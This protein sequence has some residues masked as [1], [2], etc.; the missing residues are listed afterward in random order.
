[1]PD[2]EPGQVRPFADVLHEIERGRFAADISE[3]LHELTT[4]VADTK[5]GGQIVVV[6]KIAPMKKNPDV[7]EV[8]P[9]VQLKL[10]QNERKAALFYSND[11]NLQRND[12]NQGELFKPLRDVSA[13]DD[14][15]QTKEKKA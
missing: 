8:L 7:L 1:M 15:T 12:P 13:G 9:D 10:P 5:R 3:K 4:R 14:A 2:K 11:G 6:L